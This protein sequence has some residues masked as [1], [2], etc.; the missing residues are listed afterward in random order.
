MSFKKNVS[1][2][3]GA[4]LI[5]TCIGFISSIII[6]RILGAYGRGENAIFSNS[7]AFAALFFGFSINSTIPYFIN[8]GKAKAEELLST[9]I[10]YIFGSTIFV[11]FALLLLEHFGKLNWALPSP[12]QSLEYKFIFIGIYFTSLTN[13]VLTSFLSA[14]K[15][16]KLISIYSVL[17]QFLPVII[18]LLL[19][20]N[21]IHYN[22]NNAFKIVV[23]ITAIFAGVS[24]L[25]LILLLVRFLSIRPS[26]KL[27]PTGLIKQFVLFSS[28]AY[29]G[30]VATFFNCK[31]DFWVIDAYCG[32]SQLGVYSL[33]AQL[34]Q[35]LWML[36]SAISTVLY[37][38]ACNLSKEEAVRYTIKLKQIAFYAT[39]F[40]AIIGL[41]LSYFFIPI[42]Y[43]D[44]FSFVFNLM[45]IFF[46]GVIPFSIPTVV[47]S[48]F[49][50]RGNFKMS[51]IISLIVL[52]ISTVLYFTLIPRFGLIGGAI[53]SAI[54]YL[55]A[56]IM[57]EFWFC[58][59]YKVHFFNLFIFEHNFLSIKRIKSYFK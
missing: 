5:N 4:Q 12:I 33:A 55:I 35:L 43:G 24:A 1:F 18:Y 34:S 32:K 29:V 59:E 52:A 11:Y 26:K 40:F 23:H 48:L 28:M 13:G 47:A 51:F 16:F 44:E 46:I 19:Y 25:A 58:K 54:A 53:A 31:L 56:A 14:Y 15:E 3:F 6:T 9:I 27:I 42:L 45:C 22:H 50:A 21:V 30:N 10:V 57:C 49:A 41:L 20:F 39:L 7:I 8:S 36:P 37:A 2:T 38:Y 17:F